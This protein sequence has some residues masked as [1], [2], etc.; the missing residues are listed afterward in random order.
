MKNVAMTE[1]N[2][3]RLADSIAT[4]EG[5]ALEVIQ[6]VLISI[7]L[8]RSRTKGESISVHLYRQKLAFQGALYDKCRNDE[9]E[10]NQTDRFYNNSRRSRT[11]GESISIHIYIAVLLRM[12]KIAF[13]GALYGKCRN[14]EKG[15][16]D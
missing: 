5:L 8:Y 7:L 13:Q 1:K 4:V 3:S 2:G 9:K 11:K 6:S 16:R 12:T 10:R 14:D 15:S